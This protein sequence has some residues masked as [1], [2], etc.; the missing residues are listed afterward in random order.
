MKGKERMQIKEL[1][2]RTGVPR[3]TIHYYLKKGLLHK[4]E[5]T[6]KTRAYFDASHL[7][8][9]LLI[10]GMKQDMGSPLAFI[11][12]QLD[13]FDGVDTDKTAA[14]ISPKERSVSRNKEAVRNEKKQKIIEG[15][16]ELFSTRGYHH[17]NVTDIT[18]FT[19][20]STGTFY[21]FFK[22]KLDLFTQAVEK[23]VR[24]TI[25]ESEVVIQKEKDFFKRNMLRARVLS[26]NHERLSEIIAQLRA[27]TIGQKHG[28]QDIEKIYLELTRPLVQD[29]R[30]A[31]AQG[32]IRPVDPELLAF[33]LLGMCDLLLHRGT[34]DNKYDSDRII[35]F[36]FDVLMNGLKPL[37]AGD[38]GTS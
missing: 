3:H 28:I 30:E 25:A 35:A 26:K 22:D 12:K 23:V 10:K 27:E 9:L 18:D 1:S 21:S 5:K 6:G 7:E 15:A 34:L 16:I 8:R 33:G 19:G 38:R 32:V 17:A 4:P 36:I 31:A 11:K 2:E 24:D 37:R 14:G 20:I 29:I 13:K